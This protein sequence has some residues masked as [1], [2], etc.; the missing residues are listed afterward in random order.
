[1]GDKMAC[2]KPTKKREVVDEIDISELFNDIEDENQIEFSIERDDIEAPKIPTEKTGFI[3]K[4]SKIQSLIDDITCGG[5]FSTTAL[6]VNDDNTMEV[7][8]GSDMVSRRVLVHPVN[9]DNLKFKT[10]G[11][12]IMV[13]NWEN[14]SDKLSFIFD[15]TDIV[16]VVFIPEIKR[17][18]LFKP[19]PRASLQIEATEYSSMNIIEEPDYT[20]S[21]GI[22]TVNDIELSSLIKTNAT[23]IK[24]IIK[25]YSRFAEAKIPLHIVDGEKISVKLSGMIDGGMVEMNKPI[26]PT[27][28]VSEEK[29][30]LSYFADGFK[31]VISEC[32]GGIEMRFA[33]N[34]SL[35][36]KQN[37]SDVEIISII[38]NVEQE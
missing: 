18:M 16:Q 35:Y 8:T 20:E 33:N 15:S 24:E 32:S 25:Y 12:G 34:S 22:I 7:C 27:K 10:I 31:E 38:R 36:V 5:I 3:W 37:T 26:Y 30:V 29:D 11:S 14:L 4:V 21:D 19:K 6:L 2:K 28:V 17:I 23:D 9:D 13:I 1:M